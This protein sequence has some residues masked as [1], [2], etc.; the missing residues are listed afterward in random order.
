VVVFAAPVFVVL[1]LLVVFAV[2]FAA[3]F[4]AADVLDCAASVA[5]S[6]ATVLAGARL[7]G[8]R[9]ARV[10]FAA[11]PFEGVVSPVCAIARS[12]PYVPPAKVTIAVKSG[13]HPCSLN[14]SFT[15]LQQP[16]Q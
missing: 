3:R 14:V 15:M 7:V 6:L 2:V 13:L 8:R 9:L 4:D 16:V 10:V 5:F 1:G 12:F 11:W